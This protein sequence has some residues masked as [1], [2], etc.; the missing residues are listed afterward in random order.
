MKECR[1]VTIYTCDHCGKVK[2][3]DGLLRMGG[4]IFNGWYHITKTEST[5]VVP[6]PIGFGKKDFC[7]QECIKGYFT[8]LIEQKNEKNTY[9]AGH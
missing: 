2:T 9:T 7:S 4:S 1:N 5:T 3:D 6:K 8:E